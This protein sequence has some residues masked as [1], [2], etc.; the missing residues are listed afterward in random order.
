MPLAPGRRRIARA[1]AL[2]P[3][4]P[5]GKDDFIREDHPDLLGE[6]IDRLE[7]NADSPEQFEVIGH[8]RRQQDRV[9]QELDSGLYE[10]LPKAVTHG[11]VHPG[12]MAFTDSDVSAVFDFDYMSIQAR[13]RDLCDA[14][15]FFAGN[16]DTPLDCDDIYSLAQPCTLDMRRSA[17]LLEGYQSAAKDGPLGPLVDLDWQGLPPIMR[18]QWCQIRLRGS[19]KIPPKKAVDFATDKFLDMIDWIDN[20][21][22]D[23]FNELRQKVSL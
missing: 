22:S 4:F 10:R 8:I 23:F 16:R 7:A 17:I 2:G 21:S 14:L 3:K 20:Q 6:Y 15:M 18:S 11:D 13:A 9:R 5:A 1:A 19:R 12:N